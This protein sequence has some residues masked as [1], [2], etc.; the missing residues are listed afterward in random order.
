[1]AVGVAANGFGGTINIIGQENGK[2]IDYIEGTTP[3]TT[4]VRV[5]NDAKFAQKFFFPINWDIFVTFEPTK[6]YD[7]K[8]T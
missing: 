4:N 7:D 2:W 1:L 3:T 5:Y 6:N 8:A